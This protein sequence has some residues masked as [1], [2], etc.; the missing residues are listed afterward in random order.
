MGILSVLSI[1]LPKREYETL[2]EYY[3]RNYTRALFTKRMM[4]TSLARRLHESN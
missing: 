3:L 1:R 2:I 4:I